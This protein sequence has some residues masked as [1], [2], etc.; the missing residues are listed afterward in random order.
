MDDLRRV[1]IAKLCKVGTEYVRV[2]IMIS[3]SVARPDSV[4]NL[5]AAQFSLGTA[6]S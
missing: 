5:H 6:C 3:T 2:G 1:M 4:L